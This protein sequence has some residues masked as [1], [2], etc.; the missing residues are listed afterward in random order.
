MVN[1]IT[2]FFPRLSRK[3]LHHGVILLDFELVR[4]ILV[5]KSGDDGSTSKQAA[6]TF[7]K[8]PQLPH[9]TMVDMAGPH[10]YRR[11]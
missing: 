1:S 11:P 4:A 3:H 7:T 6:F 8:R 10:R 9:L 2:M 5:T